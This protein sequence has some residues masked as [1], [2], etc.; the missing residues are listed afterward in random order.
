[1][2]YREHITENMQKEWFERVSN[3]NNF[4][5]IVE[6]NET[7]LGLINTSNID[8]DNGIADTGLFVW[9]EIYIN[10]HIPVLASL[11][12]LDVFF[13]IFG[14]KKVTAKVKND[15][16]KAIEYNVSLGYKFVEKFKNSDFSLFVLNAENYFKHAALLRKS[17][18]TLY[19]NKTE[20]LL[21]PE[22]K[23]TSKIL[24]IINNVPEKKKQELNL[25]LHHN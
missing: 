1:M 12:M 16:F 5:F 4:F 21:N 2:E 8:W 23:Q 14:L 3:I 13:N 6:Y 20:I 18:Q 7:P 15:N 25:F 11:S 24:E 17:A 22:N 10:S 9:E 19:N